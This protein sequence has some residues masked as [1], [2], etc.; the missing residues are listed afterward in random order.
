MQVCRASLQPKTPWHMGVIF[1]KMS[2]KPN[3]LSLFR[4][5]F[6]VSPILQ[7][8]MSIG[9]P[10]YHLSNLAHQPS[11][12]SLLRPRSDWAHAESYEGA[13]I[14]QRSRNREGRG[15]KEQSK[16]RPRAY[17]WGKA[18]SA[19]LQAVGIF[20]SPWTRRRA[21][22]PLLCSCFLSF[23]S[24]IAGRGSLSAR[25]FEIEKD[26]PPVPCLRWE[27]GGVGRRDSR[28]RLFSQSPFPAHFAPRMV[29]IAIRPMPTKMCG[30]Q[31]ESDLYEAV[32]HRL[33]G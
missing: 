16:E 22:S 3:I 21:L 20:P 11:S 17:S 13:L 10:P 8:W 32:S 6:P 24:V 9:F 15:Q 14:S 1:L 2:P 12:S 23:N 5:H 27:R 26:S 28:C 29:P 19:F 31:F 30:E 7:G 33:R 4:Q 18:I 25:T